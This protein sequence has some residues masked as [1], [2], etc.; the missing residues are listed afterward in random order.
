[1]YFTEKR[2]SEE[3]HLWQS[4]EKRKRG[5]EITVTE[6]KCDLWVTLAQFPELTFTAGFNLYS[7]CSTFFLLN[8]CIFLLHSLS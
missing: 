1:M 3:E 2:L 7:P 5:K 8:F 6:E 4:V